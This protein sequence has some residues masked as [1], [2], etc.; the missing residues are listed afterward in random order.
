MR[1]RPPA[2]FGN[3]SAEIPF[4]SK[5]CGGLLPPLT[6]NNPKSVDGIDRLRVL[7]YNNRGDIYGEPFAAKKAPTHES[8]RLQYRRRIF[9]YDLYTQQTWPVI[10]YR[11][12]G[13][14]SRRKPIYRVRQNRKGTAIVAGE[15]ISFFENR[16]V[17]DYAES[18]PCHPFIRGSGGGKPPPYHHRC[19]LWG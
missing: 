5:N 18:Y 16:S 11:R 4:I 8:L 9:Y 6:R 12:A 10:S 13:A 19:F 14:C 1:S 7:L 15:K 3:S 17:C 2:C